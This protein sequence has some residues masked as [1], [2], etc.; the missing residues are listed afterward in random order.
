MKIWKKPSLRVVSADK[1]SG[2]IRAAAY[3]TTSCV[4]GEFR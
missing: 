1:L 3:S 2:L 4:F